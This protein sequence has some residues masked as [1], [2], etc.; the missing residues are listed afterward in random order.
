VDHLASLVPGPVNTRQIAG[1]P[2]IV[3]TLEGKRGR[4]PVIISPPMA[5]TVRLSIPST[6]K[7][8]KLRVRTSPDA[9]NSL[10]HREVVIT[11]MPVCVWKV[12]ISQMLFS[13]ENRAIRIL[14]PEIPEIFDT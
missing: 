8:S 11:G 3:N 7:Y 4:R 1:Q 14:P 5:K 10:K 12:S 13:L 2:G 9:G 6:G